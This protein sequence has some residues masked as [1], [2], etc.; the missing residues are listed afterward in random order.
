MEHASGRGL[1]KRRVCV[2]L[3]AEADWQAYIRSMKYL[4]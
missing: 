3:F 4:V 1:G 2:L